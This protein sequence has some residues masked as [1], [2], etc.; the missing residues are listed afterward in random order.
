MSG[1]DLYKVYHPET[2]TLCLLPKISGVFFRH[3]N[4]SVNIS[5]KLVERMPRSSRKTLIKDGGSA[6]KDKP[7]LNLHEFLCMRFLPTGNVRTWWQL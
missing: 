7:N 2:K 4:L 5:K 6:F 1:D 3:V